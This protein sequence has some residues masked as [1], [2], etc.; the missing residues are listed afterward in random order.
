[1]RPLSS[2]LLLLT[3]LVPALPLS[4][5]QRPVRSGFDPAARV[6]PVAGQPLHLPAFEARAFPAVQRPSSIAG[7]VLTALGAG[8]IGAGIGYFASQVVRGDWEDTGGVDRPAWAAVGGSLGFA[9]GFSF[10]IAGRGARPDPSRSLPGGRFVIE[11]ADFR[12]TGAKTAREIVEVVRPEWLRIRG[13]HVLGEDGDDETIQVYLDNVHLGGLRFLS[14]IP[15]QTVHAIHF[16]DAAAATLR[17][18]AGHSHGVIL[19]IAKG[20]APERSS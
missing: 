17:Y 12:S 18:G 15:A 19:V 5:Q 13:T 16:L 9:L 1:M 8:A 14:D 4:A 2:S 20:G 3:V 10:P 7:R 11:E 6:T